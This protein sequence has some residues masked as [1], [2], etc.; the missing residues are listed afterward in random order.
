MLR[1]T[2]GFIVQTI[3][4]NRCRLK[5]VSERIRTG[6]AISPTA[7]ASGAKLNK[8]LGGT[9]ANKGDV[10]V[11]AGKKEDIDPNLLA[12][13]AV[14]E[15]GNGTNPGSKNRNN[16]GGM[17]RSDGK[18]QQSFSSI[19]E[20]IYALAKLLRN[21]YFDKGITSIPAIQRKYAP[22]GAGNDPKNLN[23]YWTS[24]VSKYYKMFSN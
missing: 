18:G 21:N 8:T 15:T 17:M 6:G 23:S 22:N 9:L 12:A 7:T 1:R 3:S 16:V 13:I 14:H 2:N 24:G 19:D 11:A 4:N 10:F 5:S 20:G